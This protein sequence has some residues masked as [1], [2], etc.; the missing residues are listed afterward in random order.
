MLE[1]F[2]RAE[3]KLASRKKNHEVRLEWPGV[4]WSVGFFEEGN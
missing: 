2:Y 4:V 1:R 3:A